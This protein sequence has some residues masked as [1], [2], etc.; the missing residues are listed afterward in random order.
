MVEKPLH[1]FYINAGIYIV[2]QD[3]I[4]EIGINENIDLPSL[5][6]RHIAIEKNV[7]KFPVHEYWLDI[8]RM[9]DFHRAQIDIQNLGL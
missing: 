6:E 9:E 4:K 2:S 7:L 3:I 5:L 1:R 8:G